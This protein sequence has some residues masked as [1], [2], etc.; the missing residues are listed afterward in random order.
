MLIFDFD[1]IL[2]N[3]VRENAVTAF[4]C[5]TGELTTS[6][7]E[8]P[9]NTAELFIRNR[10][11]FQPAG[12]APVLMEWCLGNQDRDPSQLLSAKE[13]RALIDAVHTPVKERTV[14]F[15]EA[16]RRFVEKDKSSWLALNEPYQPLWDDLQ[17]LGPSD[18]VIL[19][20]KNRD[21]VL[22]LAEYFR[23]AIRPENVYSGDHGAT[24]LEN[25]RVL[26]ERFGRKSH[27]FVD[28]SLPNL[29]ELDHGWNRGGWDRG[30]K[31]LELL[32]GGWGY[33]APDDR[34]AAAALGIPVVTQSEILTLFQ[35]ERT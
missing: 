18:V 34:A 22:E 6:L 14:S 24:K 13:Y 33:L 31:K 19:T 8:L 32:L 12:D 10:F 2:L 5:V 16:R 29:T 25:L 7:A 27:H 15:F 35:K 11:H 20:N 21:A 3:S 9:G 23:L 26:E 17:A 4:N 28:D 1:G 30:G